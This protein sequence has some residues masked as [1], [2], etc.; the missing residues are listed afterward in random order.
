MIYAKLDPEAAYCTLLPSKVWYHLFTRELSMLRNYLQTL[1]R[2]WKIK[3]KTKIK[4]NLI[5]ISLL[6]SLLIW[7]GLS[8]SCARPPPPPLSAGGTGWG[9]GDWASYQ[10]FKWWWLERISIFRGGCWERWGNFFQG[11]GWCS[12]YIKN[13]VKS[14]I[15]NEKNKCFSLS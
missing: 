6:F 5:L 13:K 11:G 1:M 3:V 8:S 7:E 14:E 4:T 10:I 15:L 12:F 9:G 2:K